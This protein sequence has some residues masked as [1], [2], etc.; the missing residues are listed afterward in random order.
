MIPSLPKSELF[1]YAAPGLRTLHPVFAG[2]PF[3]AW[4]MSLTYGY[5]PRQWLAFRTEYDFRPRRRAVTGPA[6]EELRHRDPVE[7]PIPTTC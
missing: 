4:D 6:R 5:R 2:D 3:K 7:C 1:S